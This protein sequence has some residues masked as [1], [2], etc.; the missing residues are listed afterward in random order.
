TRKPALLALLA[1]AACRP[2]PA[3]IA[4]SPADLALTV[5]QSA[6]VHV[7][8]FDRNGAPLAAS[9]EHPSGL[10]CLWS[11]TA[12]DVA[13]VQDA[14]L[15]RARGCAAAVTRRARR[16][17]GHGALR[18]RLRARVRRA[19][20]P[21]RARRAALAQRARRLRLRP[22]Q[23]EVQLSRRH[24]ADRREEGRRSQLARS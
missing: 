16:R 22:V 11:S 7:A 9:L 14:A 3:R 4:V 23:D 2:T 10:D 12:P 24:L 17:A 6:P 5:G 19:H 18:K 20:S 21:R 1:L 8:A 15:E 13:T